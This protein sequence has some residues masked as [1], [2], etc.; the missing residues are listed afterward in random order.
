MDR[1]AWLGYRW[2][3][4][5]LG[6][7]LGRAEL[8]DLLP[9]GFQDSCGGG[10]EWSLAQ[11][12]ASVGRTRIP[13][14]I[15]PGGPLVC[16]WSVRGAPHVHRVDRLDAVRDA[17]APHESDDGGPEH[18]AAVG[19]VAAALAAVVTGPTPKG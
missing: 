3:R 5:G 1:A 13:D 16:L 10:A 4:H 11:R 2:Q 18:V 6:G 19:E 15:R 14:A 8:D 12:T 17:L 7:R 9:L